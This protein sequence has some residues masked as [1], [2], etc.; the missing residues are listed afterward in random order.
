MKDDD[1]ELAH[2]LLLGTPGP[3]GREYLEPNSERELKARTA[4][5]RILRAEAPNGY[6]T[7]VLADLIDPPRGSVIINRKIVFQRPRG[8]PVVV[9][10]RR[11]VEIA[12]F[13]QEQLEKQK[14]GTCASDAQARN[15]KPII[16]A[17]REKFG[18][19]RSTIMKIWHDF[20]PPKK[21][22]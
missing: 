3:R 2:E 20:R 21:K 12:A 5:A 17:A 4:L 10:D 6:F 13:M 14:R 1:N 16:D 18:D 22:K 7:R 11:R 9:S 8:T 15:L 19:S